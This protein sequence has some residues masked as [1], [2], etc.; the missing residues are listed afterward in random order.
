MPRL[1]GTVWVVARNGGGAAVAGS[2]QLGG[3]QA[4]M[5][6]WWRATPLVSL[7]ARAS[8]PLASA[9]REATVGV[10][11][12]HRAVGLIVERRFALDQ[13]AGSGTIVTAFGGFDR[14]VGSWRLDGYAQGGLARGDGFADGAIRGGHRLIDRGALHL[15][16]G[17]AVWGGAQAGIARLDIGPQVV[18]RVGR[19]GLSAEWRERIAGDAR[20]GSGPS[21]TLVGD[22]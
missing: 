20:P 18:A 7:T 22:F 1:S 4:G 5:R 10:A 17:A 6:L 19:V 12:R 21:L 13:A 2:G 15:T 14:R 11:I 8:A 9:G 16:V 3:A